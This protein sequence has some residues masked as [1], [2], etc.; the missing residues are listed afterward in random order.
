MNAIYLLPVNLYGPGDNF[1]P[2]SSHVIP[3]LIQ[4]CIAAREAGDSFITAWGTGSASREFLYVDDAAEGILLATQRY[5]DPDPVNLGAGWEITIRELTNLVAKLCRYEGEVAGTPPSRTASRGAASMC[6]ARKSVLAFRPTPH[7]KR[8]LQDDC[9]VRGRAGQALKIRPT[10]VMRNK[11]ELQDK[12]M[13]AALC[14]MPGPRGRGAYPPP[15]PLMRRRACQQI[16][17]VLRGKMI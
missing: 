10:G 16:I 3:S 4:K 13:M 15:C 1:D 9:L 6:H 14:A 8:A 11:N 5:N 7:L 17:R 12:G 2:E